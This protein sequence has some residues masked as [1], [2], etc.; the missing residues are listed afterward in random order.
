ML[1]NTDEKLYIPNYIRTK[2]F[3]SI[4]RDSIIDMAL[5][6]VDWNR[7][8]HNHPYYR[9]IYC[10][11]KDGEKRRIV[12]KAYYT[13]EDGMK[14]LFPIVYCVITNDITSTSKEVMDFYEARGNS[15]NF[16]KELKDDF[17]AG[18]LSHNS[19]VENEMEFLISSFSYNLYHIFQSMILEGKDERI[20]MNTFRLRYQKIAVKVIQ[21][22][23][24]IQ[25]S[26]SSAYRRQKQFKQY[27]NKV[28]QL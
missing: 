4:Q 15:E 10:P 23:R 17:N 27:W 28:L 8:D 6:Y 25:L 18:I 3:K 1:Q 9:D 2:G 11:M 16:T 14:S 24:Q 13:N 20:R 12:Y 19:F 22:A 7:Y 5:Q 21:H 26:F